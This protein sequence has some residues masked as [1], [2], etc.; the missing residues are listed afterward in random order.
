MGNSFEDLARR[1]YRGKPELEAVDRKLAEEYGRVQSEPRVQR[2]WFGRQDFFVKSL[3][4]AAFLIVLIFGGLIVR[5]YQK[6]KRERE[7]LQEMQRALQHQ[8]ELAAELIRKA[9]GR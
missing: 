1:G 6:A 4:G 2:G 3:L 5:D 9:V 8:Q 7:A